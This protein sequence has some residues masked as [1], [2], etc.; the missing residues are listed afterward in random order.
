ME[1]SIGALWVQTGSK[2]EYWTGNIELPDGTK[3]N[4]IVFKNNY[5]KDNQPDFRIFEKK[6]KEQKEEQTEIFSDNDVRT[7]VLGGKI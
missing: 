5:K 1:K 3:Q 7:S 6:Q 4:V 2:G